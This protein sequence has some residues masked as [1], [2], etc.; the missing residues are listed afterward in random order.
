MAWFGSGLVSQEV[1]IE[2]RVQVKLLKQ[3]GGLALIP[4]SNRRIRAKAWAGFRALAKWSP[5]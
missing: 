3:E 5:M 2:A 4:V 1:G